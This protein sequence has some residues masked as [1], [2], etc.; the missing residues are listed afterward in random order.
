MVLVSSVLESCSSVN[1]P[2][3]VDVSVEAVPL[4]AA[5]EA[6]AVV[7]SAEADA[8]VF[9]ALSEAAAPELS[10]AVLPAV[11]LSAEL[12]SAAGAI[13]PELLQ[14]KAD[15]LG[16]PVHTVKNRQTG[17]LGGAILGAV[18]SGEYSSVKEA[19]GAMVTENQVYEPDSGRMQIYREKLEVYKK[20]YPSIKEINHNIIH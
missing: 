16:V 18:V 7:P 6:S 5:C 10:A 4:S 2:E 14:I 13:S 19:V 11:A 12:L 3:F 9:P 8:S 17:T 1:P 20:I 15:I